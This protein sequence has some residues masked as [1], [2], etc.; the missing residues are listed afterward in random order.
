MSDGSDAA[1]RVR[2]A[3]PPFLPLTVH[4][5]VW[6]SSRLVRVTLVGAGVESL[7]APDPAASVR[8]LVPIDG[9]LVLPHWD[10]N[11]FLLPDGSRAP[12][13]TMTP[14]RVDP[15]TGE[16][17]LEIVVHGAGPAS[18]WAASAAEGSVAAVSGPARGFP[19]PPE[20]GF[21]VAGDE[22]AIAA[23]S[24][25]LEAIPAGRP[26]DTHVEVS[27]PD[28]RVVLPDH[29]TATV[30]WH[31]RPMGAAPGSTLTDA[32][33]AATIADDTWVWAAGEAAAMQRIRRHLFDDRAIP[34]ARTWIR[35]YWKHGRAGDDAA[36]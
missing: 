30:T 33:M 23:I 21:V 9:E 5:V 35:G 36:D 20:G 1:T 28:A 29:P 16:L 10:R 22:S 32:V 17:D 2:R 3:P 34:R 24:L 4:R 14:R 26:I 7:V 13:R 15:A 31:D 12:I 19:V 18:T 27:R 25:L 8:L 6:R 11:V